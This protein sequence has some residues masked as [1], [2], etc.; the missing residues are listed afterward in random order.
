M[1]AVIGV[2]NRLKGDD[3]I[4]NVVLARLGDLRGVKKLKGAPENLT[5]PLRKLSPS[6]AY[7][8]DAVDFGGRPGEVRLYKLGDT[9]TPFPSTHSFPVQALRIL[10][11]QTEFF[12][13]G[14]QP[15]SMEF[16]TKI[17]GEL[18]SRMGQI[19]EDVRAVILR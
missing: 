17:S 19:V 7:L 5:A 6:E 14:I 3:N 2:G 15:H 16:S 8:I 4:G 13:I 18:S 12:V 11:P 10:L 9:D 1:K